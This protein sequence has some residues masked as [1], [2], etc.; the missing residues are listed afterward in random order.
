[1]WQRLWSIRVNFSGK[2]LR[3]K[4]RSMELERAQL[5]KGEAATWKGS[6]TVGSEGRNSAEHVLGGLFNIAK[7]WER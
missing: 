2:E 7:K 3:K 6:Q 4:A 1:M 5:E